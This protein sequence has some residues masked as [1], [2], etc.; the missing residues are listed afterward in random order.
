MAHPT[1]DPEELPE[2]V[3]IERWYHLA[4]L[5]ENPWRPTFIA[6]GLRPAELHDAGFVPLSPIRNPHEEKVRGAACRSMW[7]VLQDLNLA[8]AIK[9]SCYR[10]EASADIIVARI[11]PWK[12][13][14]VA[15]GVEELELWSGDEIEDIR[16]TAEAA[17]ARRIA[18]IE[19]MG[20]AG[21]GWSSGPGSRPQ[22]QGCSG[23]ASGRCT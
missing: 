11:E 20:R 17:A 13:R 7:E 4:L 3:N 16:R 2:L 15:I 22:R 23:R 18:R 19:R 21:G 12:Q 6:M 10:L 5:Y 8:C 1:G 14:A 9:I